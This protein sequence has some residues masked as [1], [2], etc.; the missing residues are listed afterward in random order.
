MPFIQCVENTSTICALYSVF[1]TLLPCALCT[2]CSKQYRV[3]FIQC[4][5]KHFYRMPFTQCVE[6]QLYRVPFIHCVQ[7]Q[8]YHIPFFVCVQKQARSNGNVYIIVSH[9]FYLN[10][11]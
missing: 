10:N 2:V 7:K 4:V 11:P 9:G 5:Q 6:K 8:F 1:K 3:A